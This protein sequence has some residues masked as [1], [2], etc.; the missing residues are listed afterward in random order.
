MTRYS[1]LILD[2]DG[3]LYRGPNPIPGAIEAVARFRE[4]CSILCLSNNGNQT[5]ERLVRR[6]R[7]MGFDVRDGELVCSLDLIVE[8]VNDLGSSLRILT[9]S[10]GDLDGALEEAGHR[11]VTSGRADAVVA[12]VDASI[13]YDKLAHALKALLA[14]AALIGANADATYPT[15]EG[16]R[17]AAGTFVGAIAAM[18]F[19]PNRMCGKPD[20][21]AMRAAFER[22]GF[23]PGPD[24]LLIGDRVD[25]DVLGA[26]A[27]GIDSALVLTGVSGREEI[28]TLAEP[29]T[30]VAESIDHVRRIV[31]F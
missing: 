7:G 27:L 30:Y 13:T 12:G 20:P 26:Q 3:T 2:L 17:P 11:V 5:S 28:G 15:H 19:A 29:P 23:E 16:P 6:L 1:K 10:S 9:I 4:T 24:C 22:R 31:G 14:G 18:G 25:A 8:A 21:C